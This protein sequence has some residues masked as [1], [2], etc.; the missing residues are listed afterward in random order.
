ME[1]KLK[2]ILKEKAK[3]LTFGG[4]SK[5]EFIRTLIVRG[6]FDSPVTT[7]KLITEVR[8]TFGKK[9][10]ATEVNIYMKKFMP[11]FIRAIRPK[12]HQG[13]FW[14]LASL[15][16]EIALSIINTDYLESTGAKGEEGNSKL[17]NERKLHH[18]V[19][20]ISSKL[21]ID[22]H[23]S[24]AI[25]EA[26]KLLNKKV[27]L[28]SGS[29][30]DG[31]SLMLSVFSQKNPKINLNRLQNESDDNEQEGFMHIFAGV[32]QGIKNPKSHDIIYLKDPIRALEYLGLISLLFR[33][34]DEGVIN[35]K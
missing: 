25:F 1:A 8:E 17:F 33:R 34:L 28:L 10:K 13:N 35:K 29:S 16:K 12:G 26:C 9:I 27:Q 24:Q 30:L 5:Y 21:F 15:P 14:F 7:E 18:E 22:G 31:K 3:K 2:H 6:F 11:E 19:S 20:K 4:G 23:Y 32:M